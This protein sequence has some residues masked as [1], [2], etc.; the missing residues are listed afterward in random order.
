[1][2][3]DSPASATGSSGAYANL[4]AFAEQQRLLR[5]KL[6]FEARLGQMASKRASRARQESDSRSA[7]TADAAHKTD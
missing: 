6:E 1:M 3:V 5:R 7:D 2:D 4:G